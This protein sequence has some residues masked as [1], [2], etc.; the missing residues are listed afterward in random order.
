VVQLAIIVAVSYV[1][2]IYIRCPK[3]AQFDLFHLWY[4]YA[5]PLRCFCSFIFMSF[6]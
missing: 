6:V 1:V 5:E 2:N 4:H 3:S